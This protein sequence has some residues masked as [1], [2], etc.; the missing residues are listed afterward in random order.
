MSTVNLYLRAPVQQTMQN[1]GNQCTVLVVDLQKESNLSLV[2]VCT[3]ITKALCIW[4]PV[5]QN[6]A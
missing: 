1:E 4:N 5:S 6:G 2:F 3:L